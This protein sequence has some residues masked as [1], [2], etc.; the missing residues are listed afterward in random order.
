MGVSGKQGLDT[1]RASLGRRLPGQLL[2]QNE[3]QAPDEI[4]VGGV[5]PGFDDSKSSWS[6]H[7][8]IDARCGQTFVDT[9]RVFREHDDPD[10]L[11]PFVLIATWNDYEEGTAIE[12]GIPRCNTQSTSNLTPQQPSLE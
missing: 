8:R 7:R 5:W 12:R 10:H 1:Q 6:L 3:G 11:I 9:M 2:H 4:T